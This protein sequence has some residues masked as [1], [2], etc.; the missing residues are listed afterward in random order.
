[1][2]AHD[3]FATAPLPPR[4]LDVK[5]AAVYLSLRPDRL[6]RLTDRREIPFVRVGR[7]VLFDVQDLEGWIRRHR[8]RALSGR[9]ELEALDDAPAPGGTLGSPLAPQERGG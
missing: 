3:T 5:A 8:V 1:M 6:Y 7:R 9:A 4:L 2:S